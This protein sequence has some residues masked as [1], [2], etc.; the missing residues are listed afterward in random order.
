MPC[1]LQVLHQ[2]IARLKL[3]LAHSAP[4][5]RITLVFF[6]FLA[7]RRW[8]QFF[9][10]F[11]SDVVQRVWMDLVSRFLG[12][13]KFPL[14]TL[15][16]CFFFFLGVSLRAIWRLL[17]A[18]IVVLRVRWILTLF[19]LLTVRYF[20]CGYH[21]SFS[22]ILSTIIIVTFLSTLLRFKLRNFLSSFLLLLLFFCLLFE[23]FLFFAIVVLLVH[24]LHSFFLSFLSHVLFLL[25]LFL[26]LFSLVVSP[27]V[28]FG[29]LLDLLFFFL[30]FI[31]LL[32]LSGVLLLIWIWI[33]RLLTFFRLLL[34]TLLSDLLLCL[35]IK[36]HFQ[37][38]LFN[39]VLV[40]LRLQML[41]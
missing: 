14:F 31:L 35:L 11:A 18:A 16:Q 7:F 17:F 28:F 1:F 36:L 33:F 21:L 3:R 12:F 8:F 41:L 38:E 22:F 20:V 25:F 24:L 30:D 13:P 6:V 37:L 40:R 19:W 32:F 27:V 39:R 34:L 2:L 26:L 9:D 23:P 4:E 15:G 10:H 5:C 29:F